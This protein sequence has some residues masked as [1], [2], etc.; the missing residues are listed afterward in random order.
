LAR[1]RTLAMAFLRVADPRRYATLWSDLANQQT[2]GNYQYPIDL[3]AAYSMLLNYHA[4]IQNRSQQQHQNKHVTTAS[5]SPNVPT[6]IGPHT[7]AQT[8]RINPVSSASMVPGNDGIT[9][10]SVTC[11]SCNRGGHYANHCPSA[12]SLVQHAYM[13]TQ[14]AIED[15]YNAI[16]K[17]WIFLDSQSNIS[18]FNSQHMISNI[19]P[20]PQEVC[21]MTNGRQQTSTMIGDFKSLGVVWFNPNSIANI[22]S[23]SDV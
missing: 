9:H 13:L 20:S 14:S 11:F 5:D 17:H 15:R 2:I 12:I 1:G 6:D 18:V 10:D 21:S 8:A 4:P 7:F 23:L 22:L 19:R 3:T 16:P